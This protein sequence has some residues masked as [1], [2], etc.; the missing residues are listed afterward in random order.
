[1]DSRADPYLRRFFTRIF[2]IR[3]LPEQSEIALIILRD[4]SLR[5]QIGFP[6]LGEPPASAVWDVV[7]P[8][9]WK[10]SWWNQT[11]RIRLDSNCWISTKKLFPIPPTVSTRRRKI[12]IGRP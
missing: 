11:C 6:D 3:V 7:P 8:G 1:M 5:K 10:N 4:A 9:K 12:T 2:L